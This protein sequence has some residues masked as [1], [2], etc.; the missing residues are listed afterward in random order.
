MDSIVSMLEDLTHVIWNKEPG[1]SIIQIANMTRAQRYGEYSITRTLLQIKTC[2]GSEHLPIHVAAVTL[3]GLAIEVRTPSRFVAT[4]LRAAQKDT[5]PRDT[6]RAVSNLL[7]NEPIEFHVKHHEW[8]IISS[9]GGGGWSIFASGFGPGVQFW[10]ANP[11][12]HRPLGQDFKRRL[13]SQ[14]NETSLKS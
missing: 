10:G 6:L 14:A 4:E 2:Q 8:T 5:L 9:L 1:R 11:L 3:R 12:G 13:Y 7:W